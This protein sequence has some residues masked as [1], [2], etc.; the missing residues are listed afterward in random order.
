MSDDDG[1][2]VYADSD[3]IQEK[4]AIEPASNKIME[5][6]KLI[7]LA[8]VT[9]TK[10]ARAGFYFLIDNFTRLVTAYLHAPENDMDWLNTFTYTDGSVPTNAEKE[11]IIAA[12]E[13]NKEYLEQLRPAGPAPQTGGAP[14]PA[15]TRPHLNTAHSKIL[16]FTK[17]PFDI[18]IDRGFDRL[19]SYI[20]SIDTQV[21]QITDE[22]GPT[23]FISRMPVDPKIPL[24]F[25][26][27]V[28]SI[29]KYSILPF[30]S[31]LLEITKLFVLLSPVDFAI[32]RKL[33]S[34]VQ[35]I[36]EFSLG[37][38]R[39]SL[40]SFL[41]FFGQ[42]IG[43]TATIG[44]LLLNAWLFIEPSLRSKLELTLFRGAK[45]MTASFLIWLFHIFAPDMLWIPIAN[46]IE[47]LNAMLDQTTEQAS[48]LEQQLSKYLQSVGYVGYTVKLPT[49][50]EIIADEKGAP[51]LRLSYDDLQNVQR[52]LSMPI[53]QCSR[54]GQAALA[55]LMKTPAR[56]ILELIGVPTTPEALTEVCGVADPAQAPSLADTISS[57]VIEKTEILPPSTA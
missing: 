57:A 56:L 19:R 46:F 33:L 41:A 30:I 36:Y 9:D 29:P 4:Y 42:G 2:W 22:L 45:S 28:L 13:A 10:K 40:L 16:N 48:A 31:A 43:L 14:A 6:G 25:P 24:P 37:N 26:P 44:K 18:S 8:W 39:Q 15:A 51:R 11:A 50:E 38:W 35:A 53:I 17:A 23:A 7:E 34:V 52:L 54:E 27:G 21:H 32:G 47:T 12:I 3:D 20:D 1:E 5:L 49:V 55:P